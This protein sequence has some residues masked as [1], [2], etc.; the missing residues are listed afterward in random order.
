LVVLAAPRSEG[1]EQRPVARAHSGPVAKHQKSAAPGKS[2]ARHA[3]ERSPTAG[4][5]PSNAAADERDR[6][7][8][9]SPP[10]KAG[11]V[12]ERSAEELNAELQHLN[13]ELISIRQASANALQIQAERDEL[14]QNVINLERELESTK[15]EKQALDEDQRQRWFFIGAVVLAAGLLLGLIL[16]RLTWRKRSSWDSF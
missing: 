13:S 3:V 9:P 4:S 10:M 7:A 5:G 11:A 16:P 8:E 12:A 1:A 2:A 6:T 14:Q 15:R